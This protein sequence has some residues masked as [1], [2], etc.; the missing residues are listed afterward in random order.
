[1][2]EIELAQVWC[3]FNEQ[4]NL[5]LLKFFDYSLVFLTHIEQ[6]KNLSY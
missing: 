2:E 4:M 1:M 5:T 3:T 6:G